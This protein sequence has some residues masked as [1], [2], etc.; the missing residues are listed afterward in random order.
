V[1]CG[2]D[3]IARQPRATVPVESVITDAV[4]I[5]PCSTYE[6]NAPLFRVHP[7]QSTPYRYHPEIVKPQEEYDVPKGQPDDGTAT[8]SEKPIA[9]HVSI[10]AES[11]GYPS[12]ARRSQ[13][14]QIP[15]VKFS[16]EVNKRLKPLPSRV[17]P[18]QSP[19]LVVHSDDP[20]VM[21]Q[22]VATAVDGS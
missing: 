7:S 8:P 14:V 18:D 6:L 22:Y 9:T 12:S 1:H 13:T 19:M 15:D 16:T 2:G 10:A 21:S 3:G 17:C 4:P 5:G 20:S 11:S